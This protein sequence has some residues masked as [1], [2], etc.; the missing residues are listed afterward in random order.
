MPFHRKLFVLLILLLPTQLGYH[1]WPEESFVFGLKVDYLSPTVYL[2]DVV[3][4]LILSAWW[5]GKKT[6][7]VKKRLGGILKK[8]LAAVALALFLINVFVIA[9]NQTAAAYKLL[10]VVE[11]AFLAGY[12]YATKPRFTQKPLYQAFSIAVIYSSVIGIIQVFKGHTIN[13]F[14]WL[15]GERSFDFSTPGIALQAIK[16]EEYLRAYSVFSHPNSFAGF[17]LVSFLFLFPAKTTTGTVAL[18]LGSLALFLTFSQGAWL[19]GGLIAVFL[20]RKWW[21]KEAP[22]RS[23]F[24][25]LLVPLF[26]TI[27]ALS[28]TFGRQPLLNTEEIVLRKGLAQSAGQ[29]FS[30]SPLLGVGLNNFVVRLPEF[31]GTPQVSWW[32]QPVHNIF[33]LVLA[34]TG[35]V[36]IAFFLWFLYL[37]LKKARKKELGV[38]LIAVL[39]TGSLDHYWLTLQQNLFLFSILTGLVL[40][41][42]ENYPKQGEANVGGKNN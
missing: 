23:L 39:V 18:L 35:I 14:F 42:A 41:Q 38:A 20:L 15:L 19:A 24:S 32:L 3:V 5:F 21:Q 31:S 25:I 30:A 10:K 40:S 29:M 13:G 27:A 17:L 28:P 4:F 37:L 36:G 33:L 8:P 6:E 7:G 16:G 9:Q 12:V 22:K 11:V 1:F 26:L 2:T 34:E